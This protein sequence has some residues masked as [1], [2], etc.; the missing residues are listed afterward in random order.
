MTNETNGTSRDRAA[1]RAGVALLVAAAATV[2]MVAARVAADADRPTLE[3]SLRAI[4]QSPATYGAGGAS[5]LLSGAALIAGAWY[6]LHTWIIRERF[7]T[8]LVPYLLCASGAF[9][10]VSGALAIALAASVPS[11]SEAALGGDAATET[12]AVL[13]RDWVLT[14]GQTSTLR[15][16]TGSIG[17][18]VAGFA[19]IA[20]GLRQWGAGGLLR[21][22]APA[23]LVIGI[24][25]QLIWL[26]A[27]TIMHRVTGVAFFVWI[28]AIGGMLATGRIERHFSAMRDSP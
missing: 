23:S 13:P 8:P 18:A 17:F 25:M 4:A 22:I 5:R 7:G 10:A 12:L 27:A 2:V 19:L 6:L 20:A 24:G 26:D 28:V 21:R 1:W 9:T 3:E 14:V 16:L 15:W 11:P